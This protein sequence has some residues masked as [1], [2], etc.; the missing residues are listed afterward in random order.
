M[1]RVCDACVRLIPVTGA[2]VVLTA[3]DGYRETVCATDDVV[4]AVEDLH[5]ALGEGPGVDALR[6]RQPV[7]VGDLADGAD[8]R[9]PV[10][11]PAAL[12]AGARA[13]FAYP[14]LVG[15]GQLGGLL[16]YAD[17]P[18]QLDPAQR[19]QAVRIAHAASFAVLDV[20]SGLADLSGDTD[21]ADGFALD[22]DVHRSRIYQASGMVMVQL[23][24]SIEEALVRLRGHAFAHAVPLGEV[25][26]QIVQRTL[27]LDSIME[28]DND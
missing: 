28:V 25:A 4:A 12:S 7:L 3:A 21:L 8:E 16:M 9:W 24:V 6:D 19:A 26:Q 17:R 10:F 5:F 15:A 27:R 13:V 18:G 14:L 22:G 20:L 2:A 1:N 11:A 23:G